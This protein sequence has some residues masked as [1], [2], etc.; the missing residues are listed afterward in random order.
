MTGRDPSDPP[1]RTFAS[2]LFAGR[3]AVVVG[4]TSGIGLAVAGHLARLGASVVAAGLDADRAATPTGCVH[5]VEL[6]ATDADQVESLFSS[7]PTVDILVNCAGIVVRDQ[8]FELETFSRVL[9]TNLTATMRTCVLAR[10]GLARSGGCIVNTASMLSFFGGG[11]V[12]AYAASKGG[13]GQLTKSLAIA[14]AG[15]GIRVNAVAPGWIR[16][17]LTDELTASTARSAELLG[18]TPMNRWGTPD[19]VARVVTFLASPAAGF[20]TGA[21]LP[22]DGGYLAA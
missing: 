5:M 7:V 2:G 11:R 8:E 14:F 22:V 4:A 15:E 6:D 1:E 19:D 17:K 10:P 16:T 21:V 3:T 9:D 13:V 20:V 12:P 18:R